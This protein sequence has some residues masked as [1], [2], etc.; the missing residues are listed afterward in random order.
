MP[1]IFINSDDE[2]EVKIAIGSAKDDPRQILADISADKLR[3]I[4]GDGL[5]PDSIE[6]HSVWFRYPDFNDQTKIIDGAIRIENDMYQV[7]PQALRYK[8]IT[9]LAKRWTF[10]GKDGK[11]TIPNENTVKKL[12]PLIAQIIGVVL[13]SEM[14]KRGVF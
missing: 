12:H 7:N 8:R 9:Q 13:E 3:E 6:E 10:K 14:S 4:Y 2:F 5:D 1:N 11:D